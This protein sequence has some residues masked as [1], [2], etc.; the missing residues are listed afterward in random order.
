MHPFVHR[1]DVPIKDYSRLCKLLQGGILT[2]FKKFAIFFDFFSP[3]PAP[4]GRVFFGKSPKLRQ[5]L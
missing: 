4:L 5:G 1:K 2:F 3:F